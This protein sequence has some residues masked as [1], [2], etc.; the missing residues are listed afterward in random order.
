MV[1]ITMR[2]D[3][4]L[5]KTLRSIAHQLDTSDVIGQDDIEVIIVDG[6][7]R[8]ETADIA[9]AILGERCSWTAILEADDGIYAAQNKGLAL[10]VGQYVQFLNGGD[11]YAPI[12]NGLGG[13][14]S[15]LKTE[16]PFWLISGARYEGKMDEGETIRNMP[17]SWWRHALGLQSH[18]HQA[19]YFTT[20]YLRA[21]GGHRLDVGLAAD[22]DVILKCGIVSSPYMLDHPL[23]RYQGGGLSAE[24]GQQ[25][26]R[27]AVD[28]RVDRFNADGAAQHVVRLVSA[29]GF[30]LRVVKGATYSALHRRNIPELL[31]RTHMN[32]ARS[33]QR[34]EG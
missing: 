25:L 15:V 24:N 16:H 33:I 9:R 1:T 31:A 10:C 27:Q 20:G 29:F 34:T 30:G 32:R 17:H 14:V 23:I 18:C 21:I 5:S 11:S 2:D 28:I 12:D 26:R 19:C 7:A 3:G 4:G 8:R 22:F 13:V 6:A